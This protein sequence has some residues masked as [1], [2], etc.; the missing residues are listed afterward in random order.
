MVCMR[1][2]KLQAFSVL[3]VLKPLFMGSDQ[4]LELADS[5]GDARGAC[6][7]SL[8]SQVLTRLQV[9]PFKSPSSLTDFW[10]MSLTDVIQSLIDP[11]SIP[12]RAH[13]SIAFETFDTQIQYQT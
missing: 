4:A 2:V 3:A 10:Q 9:R 5:T 1:F 7:A 6:R 13:F 8:A 12:W 11:A